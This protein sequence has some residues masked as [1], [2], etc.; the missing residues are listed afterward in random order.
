MTE[1][2]AP[3]AHKVDYEEWVAQQRAK[4][5]STNAVV[6]HEMYPVMKLPEQTSPD[7]SDAGDELMLLGGSS[8][9]VDM[10]I[11]ASREERSRPRKRICSCGHSAGSHEAAG[12]VMTCV[13]GRM[14]CTCRYYREVLEVDDAR[15]FKF[16]STGSGPRHALTKGI[17]SLQKAGKQAKLLVEKTCE[18]CATPT[19][20]LIPVMFNSDRQPTHSGGVATLLLCDSCLEDMR[21]G[22]P[23]EDPA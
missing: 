5:R 15:H 9:A 1:S 7:S 16:A 13:S 22:M 4:K 8:S 12:G 21:M 18:Q 3:T 10:E 6:T 23:Y 20:L 11:D 17:R 2:E 19:P 14:W